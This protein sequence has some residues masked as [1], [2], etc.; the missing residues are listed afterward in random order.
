MTN[1]DSCGNETPTGGT[2]TE[3]DVSGITDAAKILIERMKIK[4][5]EFAPGNKFGHI[6]AACWQRVNPRPHEGAPPP[7][8]MRDAKVLLEAYDKYITEPEFT[9]HVLETVFAEPKPEPAQQAYLSPRYSD[10]RGQYGASL[11]TALGSTGNAAGWGQALT[12]PDSLRLGQQ[13]LTEDLIAKM[14]TKLGL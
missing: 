10:P 2:T 8:P 3:L 14:K 4:P 12:A 1:S 13:T 11:T 6:W 7:V 5:E 9:K